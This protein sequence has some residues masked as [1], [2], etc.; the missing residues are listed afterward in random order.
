MSGGGHSRTLPV[1]QLPRSL[2]CCGAG[3]GMADEPDT[4]AQLD[5]ADAEVERFLADNIHAGSVTQRAPVAA[6]VA[7]FVSHHVAADAECRFA[8]V[9]GGGTVAPLEQKEIRHVTNLSTGQRAAISAEHLVRRGYRVIYFHK[10]LSLLPFARRFQGGDFLDG[11][12]VGEDGAVVLPEANAAAAREFAQLVTAEQRLTRVPFHTVADYQMGMKT[13][14]ETLRTTLGDDAMSRVLVYLV[15]AVSDFFIPFKELPKE[16]IDSRP[17]AP[18]MTIHLQK[19]PKALARGLVGRRWGRDAFVTTFKLE[20]D[21]SRIDAK[22]MKHINAFSNIKL[23]AANLLEDIRREISLYDTRTP[24]APAKITKVDGVE[25][26]DDLIA[27]VV[28]KHT[29]YVAGRW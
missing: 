24:D 27:R 7:A 16:K 6:Q 5:V 12:T 10:T 1:S 18:S 3:S 19:V 2:A 14:L 17:D 25:L 4:E 13:I 9:T 29:E 11:V 21:E 26:E 20:T 28:A 23:V 8:L 15:A 22:V